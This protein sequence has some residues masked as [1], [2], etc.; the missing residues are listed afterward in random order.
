MKKTL[1]ATTL[2][3][4]TAGV[5]AAEVTLGGSGR[6]G[7]TVENDG[8]YEQTLTDVRLTFNMDAK[9]ETDSGITFGGRIRFRYNDGTSY[10]WGS[11]AM[12]YMEAN[13]FRVE[14]GNA[15]GAYDSA[16]LMWNSEIGLV[17][18]SYGD[19][20]NSYYGYFATGGLYADESMGVFA[21]YSSGAVTARASYHVGDQEDDNIWSETSV[22][23]DYSAN[24]LSLS[25]AYVEGSDGWATEKT[26]FV[27]AAYAIGDATNV[28]LNYFT[29]EAE[30]LVTLY[31]NHSLGNGVTLAGYIADQDTYDTAYGIGASYDLGGGAS[32]KGSYHDR[33]QESWADF[34]V[35]FSF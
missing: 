22:S 29:G 20:N 23:A 18:S 13:G 19:P 32:V 34:G 2:L 27:G 17:D 12:V 28:G 15:N 3:V 1:L 26:T 25:F 11:P 33:G 9:M 24:G 16:G 31:A 21:S 4:A 7:V 6:F 8:S 10:T 35:Q 30:D 5:A 14:V